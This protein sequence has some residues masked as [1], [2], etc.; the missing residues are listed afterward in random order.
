MTGDGPLLTT[1]SDRNPLVIALRETGRE[2]IQCSY[3]EVRKRLPDCIGYYGNLFSEI[4]RPFAFLWLKR[5]LAE[6]G[7]P[8]VFWNRDAPWHV[9]IKPYNRLVLKTLKPV[10]IYLA[11]SMQDADWFTQGTP[12]YFPNAARSSYCQPTPSP[13]FADPSLW[14]YDI[15]FFGAIGNE[16]RPNCLRRKGFLQ[17]IR[18]GLEGRGVAARW[19]IVDTIQEPL[20]VEQQ[21]ELIRSSRI[22]LNFGAM[23]DL[24]GNPSWGMPERVFGIPAAGGFLLTDWRESIPDT[25]PDDSCD[26]FRTPDEC[27]EKITHYLGNPE[28]L[29][30][31][32]ERLHAEVLAH[33]TYAARVEQLVGLLNRFAQAKHTASGTAAG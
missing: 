8:Y 1:Y 21:L 11:H 3:D 20:S 5:A 15:S 4:K 26:Y 22:N 27:M 29:R 13:A 16:K 6:H 28:A 24:P 30:A 25:F 32:A 10:D 9:G 17:T 12:T 33:H 7:I 19:R 31:R 23:C 14:R 2:V 18:D